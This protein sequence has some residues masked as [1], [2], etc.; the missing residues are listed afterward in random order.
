[1][2]GMDFVNSLMGRMGFIGPVPESVIGDLPVPVK[3]K[4]EIVFAVHATDAMNFDA[5]V[6]AYDVNPEECVLWSVNM[7]DEK[8]FHLYPRLAGSKQ[9]YAL[10]KRKGR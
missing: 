6:R 7:N 5:V 2:T 1:M 4:K 8:Y 9:G 10:P 3:G